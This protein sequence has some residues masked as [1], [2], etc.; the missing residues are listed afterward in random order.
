M[1]APQATPTAR[2]RLRRLKALLVKESLQVVRDPEQHPDRFR[3]AADPALSL[4]L[5]GFPWMP[6]RCAWG[7]CWRTPLRKRGAWQAPSRRPLFRHPRAA[8]RRFEED[9]RVGQRPSA[10]PGGD[11]PGFRPRPWH[12]P[13]VMARIQVIADGSETNTANYRG[14]LRR[15]APL[16]TWGPRKPRLAGRTRQAQAT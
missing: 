6:V 16:A 3:P 13:G 2:D 5:T 1:K 14:Q 8:H 4:R 9:P 11:P 15:R 7:W 10:G 12:T